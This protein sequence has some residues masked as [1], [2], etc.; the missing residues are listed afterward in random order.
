MNSGA[1]YS[2]PYMMLLPV[3]GNQFKNVFCPCQVWHGVLSM[4]L[5]DC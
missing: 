1:I 2:L 3:A 5:N 4:F